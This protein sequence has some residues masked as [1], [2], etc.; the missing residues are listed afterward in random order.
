[1][2]TTDLL[3]RLI[4]HAEDQGKRTNPVLDSVRR[5][6]K[7]L[8]SSI[9]GPAPVAERNRQGMVQAYANRR[10]HLGQTQQFYAGTVSPKVKA[11]RRAQGKM[12]KASRKA[13]RP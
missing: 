2:P 1:M 10:N 11:K 7:D 8:V 9:T 12:A 6:V 5:Q 13:N 3:P 4:K